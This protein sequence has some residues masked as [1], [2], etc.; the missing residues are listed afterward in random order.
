MSNTRTGENTGTPHKHTAHLGDA[1]KQIHES[2]AGGDGRFF[3]VTSGHATSLA[4][5]T[6]KRVVYQH[7]SMGTASHHGVVMFEGTL[8]FSALAIGHGITKNIR[9]FRKSHRSGHFY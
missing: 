9:V 3:L 6:I 5:T 1:T 2:L 4:E 7:Q 8:Q